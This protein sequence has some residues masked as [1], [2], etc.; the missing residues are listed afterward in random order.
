[1]SS[2]R[3]PVLSCS[4]ARR[5]RGDGADRGPDE[6]PG[7]PYRRRRAQMWVVLNEAALHRDRIGVRDSKNRQ[8]PRLVLA[9]GQWQQF[10]RPAQG[11]DTDLT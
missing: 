11:R 3:D 7:A 5:W 4:G 1:M 6:A 10:T 9:P 8:G 2:S